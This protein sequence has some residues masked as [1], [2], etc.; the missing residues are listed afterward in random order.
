MVTATKINIADYGVDTSE[1]IASNKIKPYLQWFNPQSENYGF[2]LDTKFVDVIDFKPDENWK[3]EDVDLQDEN[4]QSFTGK[5]WFSRTP[6]MILL[7]GY[8]NA[9]VSN[10]LQLKSDP[11]LMRLNSTKREVLYDKNV[12]KQDRTNPYYNL[13]ILLVDKEN[14]LLSPTPLIFKTTGKAK[15]IFKD[16]YK[17]FIDDSLK[18]FETVTSVKLPKQVPTCKFLSRFIFATKLA[19][20]TITGDNGL[21]SKGTVISSYET[22]NQDTFT[23]LVLP[24]DHPTLLHALSILPDLKSY[25]YPSVDANTGEVNLTAEDMAELREIGVE[26]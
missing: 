23:N 18:Q 22:I 16:K 12:S 25:L 2:A 17:E 1:F 9:L 26:F 14:N 19:K 21:S 13:V 4:K 7:N 10:K 6:R 11:M 5:M 20:G 24:N 8:V 3:L 15:S